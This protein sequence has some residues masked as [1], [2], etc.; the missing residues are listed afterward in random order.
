VEAVMTGTR[1]V[2][3]KN[4]GCLEVVKPDVV[5]QF[6]VWETASIKRAI[7]TALDLA[8]NG[9]HK[10]PEP[11]TALNYNPEVSH[12]VTELLKVLKSH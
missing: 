10:I 5:T 12:H 9:S 6:S 4:I 1:L 7:Q 3:E 8:A 11:L 2:F